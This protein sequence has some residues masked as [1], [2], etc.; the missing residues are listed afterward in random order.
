[1]GSLSITVRVPFPDLV[2]EVNDI[3]QWLVSMLV[4]IKIINYDTSIVTTDNPFEGSDI[5]DGKLKL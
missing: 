2:I 4:V 3:G 1:M 5:C